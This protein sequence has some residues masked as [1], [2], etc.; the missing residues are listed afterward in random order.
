MSTMPNRPVISHNEFA[1][2]RRELMQRMAAGAIAVLP[3]ATVRQRN[4]D[5]DFPFRQDSNFRYLCGLDEPE[6]VL[7]L[8]PGREQGEMVL[9]CRERDPEFELW[10][11]ELTGPERARQLYGID[12][13]LPIADIDKVLPG[14]M[15]GRERL[16]YQMGVSREFDNRIMGWVNA[17]TAQKKRGGS[18]PGELVQ[19]GNRLH[20][21]RLCK[22][23]EELQVMRHAAAVSG[24]AHVAAM[25]MAAAGVMEFELEAQMQHVFAR[26]G[27]RHAAYPS[28]VASGAN[29]C[30][31]HYTRNDKPLQ[32]GD[33][34]LIDAGCEYEGYAADIT[35]TFPVN[36]TFSAE[37][38]QIY[39]V[40]LA[41][42]QAAIEQIVP[43]NHCN[44]LHEAAVRTLVDGLLELGLLEG[45]AGEII[46]T[47]AYRRFYMHRTGHW[48]GLDVHDV[49]AYRSD[50]AWRVLEPGMVTTVEP[51]LYIAADD[52]GVDE[53]WRGIGVRIEDDV[54]VTTGGHEVLTDHAPTSRADIEALMREG[55][56]AFE[57]L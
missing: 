23:A 30:I 17:V 19:L 5:V 53:R 57:R 11:G 28:I 3:S 9:F 34:V 20:E 37:Q 44:Q 25:R 6:S 7:V 40:V 26:G 47:E 35:R 15:D 13:A 29:A 32:A 51:G 49:G 22:S 2:R 48:L 45:D 46:E 16:H 10:H 27:A 14:L 41:A 4:S 24:A 8:V 36:G 43:G 56:V 55:G 39:D 33:L 18:P 31:L 50:D 54:A 52:E 42:Q 1:R 38:A 12:E 21:L